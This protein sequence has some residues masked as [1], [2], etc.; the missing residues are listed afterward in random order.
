MQSNLVMTLS[1][2]FYATVFDCYCV[3]HRNT[4]I[5]NQQ[6]YCFLSSIVWGEKDHL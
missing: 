5:Q 4:R 6:N 3:K 1:P 2:Y